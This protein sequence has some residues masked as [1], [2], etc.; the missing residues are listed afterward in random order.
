MNESAN[1]R[2]RGR[3]N[4]H[5]NETTNERIGKRTEARK[6]ECAYERKHRAAPCASVFRPF[7]A[8]R[9]DVGFGDLAPKSAYIRAFVATHSN[10]GFRLWIMALVEAV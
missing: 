8:G 6:N 10:A 3:T 4:A 2:R 1:E 5:T 9:L 7:G